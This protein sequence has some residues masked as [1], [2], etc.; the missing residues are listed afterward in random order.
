MKFTGRAILNTTLRNPVSAGGLRKSRLN[1]LTYEWVCSFF[2]NYCLSKC[3]WKES[4]ELPDR[5][6]DSRMLSWLL[7]KNSCKYKQ[8]IT[9]I[10]KLDD[11][12]FKE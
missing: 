5:G 11:F 1:F 6:L 9:H 10:S 12:H 4:L 8:E 3:S 7:S 2:M